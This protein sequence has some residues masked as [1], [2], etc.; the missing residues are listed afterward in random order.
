MTWNIFPSYLT[1]Q[2]GRVCTLACVFVY[3]CTFTH[4]RHLEML[5]VLIHFNVVRDCI[6]FYFT[7]YENYLQLWRNNSHNFIWEPASLTSGIYS[8]S[9]INSLLCCP[10]WMQKDHVIDAIKQEC[11]FH[12]WGRLSPVTYEWWGTSELRRQYIS[13]HQIIYCPLFCNYI[14]ISSTT[15]RRVEGS[16]ILM[17]L[18]HLL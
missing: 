6:M 15:K 13:P 9:H 4:S 16:K 11:Y 3:V 7:K 18:I 12:E 10:P 8:I 1:R 2:K 5:I 14:Y 17:A